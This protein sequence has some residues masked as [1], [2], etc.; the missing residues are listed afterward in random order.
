MFIKQG[1]YVKELLK[2]YKLDEVK[3]SS[4]PMTLNNKLDDDISDKW[5]SEKVYQ[6][7]IGSL[8]Y[9]MASRLD[10]MFSVCLCVRFQSAP[11]ESHLTAVKRIFRY[12]TDT[13]DI[14]LWYPKGGDLNLTG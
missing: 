14:E 13:K 5:V 6:G 3:H 11:K 1:K 4:I 12:L 10:V 8:L 2:K 9:L 7:M